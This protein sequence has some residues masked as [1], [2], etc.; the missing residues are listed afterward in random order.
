MIVAAALFSCVVMICLAGYG[1]VAVKA[2]RWLGVESRSPGFVDARSITG[3][4][5][6]V[7]MGRDPLYDNPG[8]PSGTI[9]NYPRL[10]LLP[11]HLG[12]GVRHTVMLAC[13]A[14]AAFWLSVFLVIGRLTPGEGWLYALLLCSPAAMLAVERGNCD[15]IIFALLACVVLLLPS[16]RPIAYGLLLLAGFLK[17]YPIFS[18]LVALRERKRLAFITISLVA[19]IFLA[20]VLFT[21]PDIRQISKSTPRPPFAA[22][23]CLTFAYKIEDSLRFRGQHPG[24]LPWIFAL[25]LGMTVIV[26]AWSVLCGLRRCQPTT[27]P[28]RQMDAFRIGASVYAGTFLLGSNFNYRFIFLLLT[29]PQLLNWIKDGHAPKRLATGA[30]WCV[31]AAM[32]TNWIALA[33]QLFRRLTVPFAA[34]FSWALFAML[35]MLLVATIPAWMSEMIKGRL[36]NCGQR[37]AAINAEP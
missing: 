1:G 27:A 13:C 16:R 3:A 31:I 24:Y 8:D 26:L 15:L 7:R 35:V 32:W 10:W 37:A 17:L 30:L 12:L 28:T 23:G 20:Y 14:V 18:L 6:S 34:L 22:Y 19:V 9:L 29:V 5:E 36:P 4:W 2:W 33:G 11:S 25:G 21:L